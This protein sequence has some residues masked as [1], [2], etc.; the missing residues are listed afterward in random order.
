MSK[1][2]CRCDGSPRGGAGCS[3]TPGSTR[4]HPTWSL[5]LF[6]ISTVCS[7]GCVVNWKLRQPQPKNRHC[8]LPQSPTSEFTQFFRHQEATRVLPPA[9]AGAGLPPSEFTRFFQSPS[10]LDSVLRELP[11]PISL[12]IQE[13]GDFSK[14][15][16][17]AA[18]GA[19]DAP[20][21]NS[22]PAQSSPGDFTRIFGA[23]GLDDVTWTGLPG[24]SPP[25]PAAETG[26]PR[27][28]AGQRPQTTPTT[29]SPVPSPA[30][31]K[32]DPYVVL[33][34]VLA[35]LLLVSVVLIL[36]FVLHR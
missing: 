4:V 22:T 8:P 10:G 5:G 12:P 31:R 20:A 1:F 29:P 15:F 33:A 16:G 34:I 36:Y 35:V 7:S 27:G 32:T 18:P 6:L 13:M 14:M 30:R 2:S 25:K 26:A 21:A 24:S 23:A 28:P 11:Q 19:R 9:S 3:S 17:R